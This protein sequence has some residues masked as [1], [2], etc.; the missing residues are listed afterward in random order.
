MKLAHAQVLSDDVET[1]CSSGNSAAS[2]ALC[3]LEVASTYVCNRLYVL[4]SLCDCIVHLLLYL[5]AE[6]GHG[7]IRIASRARSPSLFLG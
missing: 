6:L 2:E 5:R 1:Y 7:I 3:L 4:S